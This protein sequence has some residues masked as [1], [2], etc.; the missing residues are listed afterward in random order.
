M[1]RAGVSARRAFLA[2]VLGGRRRTA[3]GTAVKGL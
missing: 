1:R 2:E 3:Q